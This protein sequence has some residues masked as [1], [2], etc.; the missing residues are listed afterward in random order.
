[1][2]TATDPTA[3]EREKQELARILGANNVA[4]PVAIG[5]ESPRWLRLM[6]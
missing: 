2:S 1:M 4:T 6:R 5:L 3:L